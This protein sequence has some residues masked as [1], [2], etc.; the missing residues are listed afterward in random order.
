MP[1]VSLENVQQLDFLARWRAYPEFLVLAGK[2]F[3]ACYMRKNYSKYLCFE[4]IYSFGPVTHDSTF[5]MTYINSKRIWLRRSN[6]F[7][8]QFSG[9]LED[10]NKRGA[11]EDFVRR[12]WPE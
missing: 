2:D 6:G 3:R 1:R 10:I 9:T 7:T 5:E 8:D 12:A 4:L 11:L